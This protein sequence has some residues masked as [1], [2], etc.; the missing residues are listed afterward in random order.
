MLAVYNSKHSLNRIDAD[1]LGRLYRKLAK[2]LLVNII[3]IAKE[4]DDKGAALTLLL[5]T[6]SLNLTSIF[7]GAAVEMDEKIYQIVQVDLVYNYAEGKM[8]FEIVFRLSIPY[9]KTPRHYHRVYFEKNKIVQNAA[10][11]DI[12]FVD[13][14]IFPKSAM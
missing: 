7:Y 10:Y 14:P 9:T 5:H 6:Y 4:L 1:E 12:K 3:G 2:D 13:V 11:T 8:V